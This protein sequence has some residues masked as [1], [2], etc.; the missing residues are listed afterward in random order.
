LKHLGTDTEI[1]RTIDEEGKFYDHVPLFAGKFI[2]SRDGKK[3]GDANRAVVDALIEAGALLAKGTLRHQYPHSW[4][5]KAPIIFRATPQWFAAI[6]KPIAEF[7]GDT[8]R[9]RAAD[10]IRTTRWYPPQSENRIA[11]MVESRPDWVLSRQRAWGVPIAIFVDRQSGEIL[12][13]ERV[14]ARII[15]AFEQDGADAWFNSPPQR[16]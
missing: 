4:R 8:L 5:S 7:G 14:N 13:D 12:E 15:A 2:L 6:D 16:F 1:P 10:S 9:R 3:D 11:S